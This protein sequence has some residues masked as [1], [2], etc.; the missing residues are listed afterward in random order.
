MF[1][2]IRNKIEDSNREK[3]G[4][5][6]LD[7]NIVKFLEEKYKNRHPENEDVRFRL[8]EYFDDLELRP[9]LLQNKTALDLGSNEHFFDEYCKEKYNTHFVALDNEG[10]KLGAKHAMGIISDAKQLP[11]KDESFDLIISHAAMPHIL[12]DFE[13]EMIEKGILTKKTEKALTQSLL[14]FFREVYRTVKQKGQIRL[15]TFCIK[16]E[17]M[18]KLSKDKRKSLLYQYQLL[19]IKLMKVALE[20]LEKENGAKCIFKDEE[21]GGLI[22]IMK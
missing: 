9:E 6:I 16:E 21:K 13:K 3:A 14:E 7:R 10:I 5:I 22:I 18:T 4:E 15:S 17:Y 8:S 2:N 11:F 20:T 19:R 1:E 12:I